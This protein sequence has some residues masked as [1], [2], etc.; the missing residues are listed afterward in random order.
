[1][2]SSNTNKPVERELVEVLV[3]PEA[4]LNVQKSGL[5]C[6]PLRGAGTSSSRRESPSYVFGFKSAGWN[7]DSEKGNLNTAGGDRVQFGSTVSG[8]DNSYKDINTTGHQLT[9]D[10]HPDHQG[11]RLRTSAGSQLYFSDRCAAPYIYI[12]TA[13]GNVWVE[14]VDNGKVN[15]FTEDSVSVHSRNDINLTA[16]RDINIDAQRDFNLQ[17]RRNTNLKLKGE[18]QFEF[19]KND[20]P[21]KDLKYEASPSWGSNTSG[22]DTSDTTIQSFGNMNLIVG[23]TDGSFPL[24]PGGDASTPNQARDL[25]INVSQD[26]DWTIGKD[27][28]MN[29]GAGVFGPGTM[30][31]RVS[32][33]MRMESTNSSF[34]L[35]TATSIA[36]H[37]GSTTDIKADSAMRLQALTIDAFAD[38]GNITMTGSSDIHL[39]GPPAAS[40]ETADSSEGTDVCSDPVLP[41][42]A[43]TFR[44]PTF[45]EIK[46]CKDPPA[47]F[48]TLDRMTVPQH[49]AW[50]ERTEC[51]TGTRGFADEAPA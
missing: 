1:R 21:P 14:M 15:I 47:E 26:V 39:N 22:S 12:T 19:G 4:A 44:V 25:C 37:S 7:F 34:D 31:V 17:V 11:V 6:D 27:L 20:L 38:G 49:Q 5:L 43:E 10:D 48:R 41:K 3:A 35:K 36:T 9:F 18:N 33:E 13:Q 23:N 28:H 45:Q 46:D 42:T 50:P 51:S 40:A 30:D 29:I 2:L 24:D 8:G 16:D 32:Q